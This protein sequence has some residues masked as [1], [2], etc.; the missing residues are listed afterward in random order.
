VV[1]V[2][3]YVPADATA[4]EETVIVEDPTTVTPVAAIALPTGL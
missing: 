3:K 2:T 4:G 1:T